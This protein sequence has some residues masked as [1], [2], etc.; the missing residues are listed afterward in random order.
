MVLLSLVQCTRIGILLWSKME[1]GF[2]C[3]IKSIMDSDDTLNIIPEKH[4]YQSSTAL[5]GHFKSCHR[6]QTH[7]HL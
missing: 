1:L 5:E 3:F 4:H 7:P 6:I 2:Q